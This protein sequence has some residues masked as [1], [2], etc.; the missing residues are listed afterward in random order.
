MNIGIKF[1]ILNEYGNYLKQILNNIYDLN[2]IWKIVEDEIYV[3]NNKVNDGF[4]FPQE[5]T[6]LTNTEFV[7]IISQE[8][9]YT[10]FANI[11]LFLKEDE[12]VINNYTD[13]IK[14]SCI[15]VLFITDNEFV[16]V[17]S[18]DENML[19]TIYKN[20]VENNFSSI[21]YITEDNFK[22]KEFSAYS[23]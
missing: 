3:A 15:L 9:Y 18:K 12:G 23:D 2:Y 4:L 11:K 5:K 16:E 14:S 6:I 7:N 20:A 22:R 17:Y 21:G 8:S 1:K 19:K 13:F 10:V